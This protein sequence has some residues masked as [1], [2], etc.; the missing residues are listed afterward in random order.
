M[1]TRL[2]TSSVDKYT[3]NE[4]HRDNAPTEI[5][6]LD[7]RVM[8]L[9]AENKIIR[10]IDN[11]TNYHVKLKWLVLSSPLH[12]SLFKVLRNLFS[13]HSLS[14]AT[15]ST[16]AFMYWDRL[17]T[18]KDEIS[19]N[20]I[21][22]LFQLNRT[23]IRFILPN[24]RRITQAN[25]PGISEDVEAWL[26]GDTKFEETGNGKYFTLIANDPEKGA[27]T[28]QELHNLHS[29]LNKAHDSGLINMHDFTLAWTFIATGLRPFQIA[30]M[31]L[32][33]VL[34]NQGPE[35]NEVTLKVN[36][37]KGEKTSN[38]EYWLRRAPTV[39]AECLT[40]Y[41]V[42][43]G[44]EQDDYLFASYEDNRNLGNKIK[45]IFQGLDTWSDRLEGPIPI[46]AYRFRYTLATRAL[47][48]GAS[49]Y[50]VARLLTHRSTSCIQYYRASM[51]ELQRPI[52]KA[53]GSEIEYFAKAF[54][55]KLI[56]GLE[57]ATYPD[58]SEQLILD[59]M[60]LAGQTLGACGTHESC[61]LNAPIACLSCHRFE[62]LEDAPWEDLLR[63]LE[64]DQATEHEE[65]IRMLNMNAMS[66]IIEIMAERDK[67]R[68]SRK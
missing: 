11:Y 60:N 1:M 14:F 17:N 40:N 32:S 68:A 66:S 26:E 2:I 27:L 19:L 59:F 39:L 4:E 33:E 3:E 35:G 65:R 51:P 64:D 22:S 48:Q 53:I 30:R 62:P 34:I 18:L 58:E 57:E 28:D 54:Q 16:Q 5:R 36:L 42:S 23:Y 31:K 45:D 37:A 9:A 13:T 7:G 24:L 49:D 38:T 20:D 56:R 46:S 21:N 63:R 52:R 47:R 61:H 10:D 67:R 43:Y 8:S 6:L 25:L 12:N 15:S 44:L 55:G 29:T 41:L 50:E